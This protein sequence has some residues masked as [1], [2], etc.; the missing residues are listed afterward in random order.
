MQMPNP[1]GLKRTVLLLVTATLAVACA[2]STTQ[3]T[4]LPKEETEAVA[5][6]A[7]GTVVLFRV[8]VD[9]DGKPVP[10]PLSMDPRWKWYFWVNVGPTRHPLDSSDAFAS[11][12]LDS[13]STNAGWGFVTLPPG[14]YQLAF[15]AHRTKFAM[16][17][18]QN[19][20]LGFGQ[21][22][23][24]QIQVPSDAGLLYIGTF[25]FACHKVDRWW[26]YVEHECT[27]VEIRD[28]GTLARQVA[29]A[30]LRRFEPMRQA[31][32]LPA[33]AESSR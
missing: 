4:S 30:S 31:L 1:L 27:K 9:D 26:A 33:P 29:S 3:M 13:A 15:A 10:A 22:S 28:D 18:A 7:R 8:A 5:G 14:N 16:S 12:Q 25:A 2:R 11:G 17:G 20:A 19:S 6:T 32:A 24:S 21:S 23:V